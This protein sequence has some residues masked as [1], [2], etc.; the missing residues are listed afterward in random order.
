MLIDIVLQLN[1]ED[2]DALHCKIISYIRLGKYQNALEILQKNFSDDNLISE[3]A[4]CLYRLNKF[5]ELL[6]LLKQHKSGNNS[7]LSLRHLEAQVVRFSTIC[8]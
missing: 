5:D 2:I 7:E 4:Y 6:N 8:L 1:P 3:K